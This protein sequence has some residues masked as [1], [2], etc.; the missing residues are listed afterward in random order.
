MRNIVASLLSILLF[1]GPAG[2]LELWPE[3]R[4]SS[5]LEQSPEREGHAAANTVKPVVAHRTNYVSIDNLPWTDTAQV[6]GQIS[7]KFRLLDPRLYVRRYNLFPAYVG[8]TQTTLWNV[9]QRTTPFEETNFNPEFFLDYPVEKVVADG[10]LGRIRWRN[11]VLS[12]LE[13]ESNGLP[14]PQSRRWN[15][16]YI[17]TSFGLEPEDKLETPHSFMPDKAS[18]YLKLWFAS[19]F[20]NID[21]YLRSVGSDD[22]F[23]EYMGD[24]EIGLS[25]RNFLFNG[26]L[27]NC[28]LDLKTPFSGKFTKNSYK[29]EFR[30][31]IPHLNYAL[32]L[33]YWYGY[34]ETLDRFDKF[35]R[36]G[37]AGLAFSF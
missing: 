33:Q 22:D 31:Q 1:A 15:R 12:P 37:F 10:V 2:A 26:N 5:E 32:Y 20:D 27:R 23:L 24:G 34:G 6:K 35:G 4:S 14:G 30:Q 9:G 36:R 16:Q 21:N 11:V 25:L 29:L 13:M 8:Y 7:M 18:L 28:Q 3:G 17:A 19:G